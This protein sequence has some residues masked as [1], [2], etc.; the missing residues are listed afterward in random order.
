ML[1]TLRDGAGSTRCSAT[2][3]IWAW[4]DRSKCNEATRLICGPNNRAELGD[5][6]ETLRGRR[7]ER[8]RYARIFGAEEPLILHH[9]W[10]VE[11]N[12]VR[13]CR[14]MAVEFRRSRSVSRNVGM[15]PRSSL[16]KRFI[17]AKE[18]LRY[19][20]FFQMLETFGMI[21]SI[22]T[23]IR[24]FAVGCDRLFEPVYRA[25]FRNNWQYQED[26]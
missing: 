17:H 22:Y 7:L 5:V 2:C 20:V 1:S 23:A 18:F 15:W 24:K 4:P 10:G 14:Q 11:S 16:G 3:S 13:Q 6:R 12:V 25:E 9:R 26:S 19:L 8:S 21:S